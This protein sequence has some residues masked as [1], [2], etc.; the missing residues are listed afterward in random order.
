MPGLA[1]ND[2]IELTGIIVEIGLHTTLSPFAGEGIIES[3][4]NR[5]QANGTTTRPA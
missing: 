2:R 4:H 5:G 1:R 3:E